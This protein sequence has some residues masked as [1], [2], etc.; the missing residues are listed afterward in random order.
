MLGHVFSANI[1][2]FIV[3]NSD[4]LCIGGDFLVILMFIWYLQ[5]FK[6]TCFYLNLY[7]A[8]LLGF[9]LNSTLCYPHLWS[10]S[11]RFPHF[12][13][14]V[15]EVMCFSVYQMVPNATFILW[16]GKF[17]RRCNF[18]FAKWENLLKEQLLFGMKKW[19]EVLCFCGTTNR[20]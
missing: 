1:K 18:Y 7:N 11:I 3:P 16:N 6:S 17:G 2:K 8:I 9:M 20:I 19:R 15:S 14:S 5:F 12:M 4:Y 10:L 13:W